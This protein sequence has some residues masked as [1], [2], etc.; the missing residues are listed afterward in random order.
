[1][2]QLSQLSHDQTCQAS[3][4]LLG[5]FWTLQIIDVLQEADLRYC[6]IQRAVPHINPVTLA[7]RLKKLEQARLIDRREETL[8]KISVCYNLTSLGREA[9]PVLAAING[10]AGK[11][12]PSKAVL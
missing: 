9:L 2:S 10:F 3:L 5:D 1:M 8:D 4:K 6:E 11:A 12:K 7:N